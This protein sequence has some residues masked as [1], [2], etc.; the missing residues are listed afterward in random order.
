MLLPPPPDDAEL[1]G[2]EVSNA[3]LAAALVTGAIL[4]LTGIPL[5]IFY[6]P[7]PAG[8]DPFGG[9][10]ASLIDWVR[11]AHQWAGRLFILALIVLLAIFV[12]RALS[13]THRVMTVVAPAAACILA[14]LAW[15]TGEL[16]P[17][18][19]I[20]ANEAPVNGDTMGYQAA[21]R[22][23]VTRVVAGG[24]E[25]LVNDLGIYLAAHLVIVPALLVVLLFVG[26]RLSARR[27]T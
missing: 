9:P 10:D 16:L 12:M 20:I 22:D 19:L 5:A 23:D 6:K 4:A 27:L 7:T 8:G 3:A 15:F 26:R 17:W 11:F 21:F 14:G 18:D 24:R 13:E 2:R 25:V 1:L